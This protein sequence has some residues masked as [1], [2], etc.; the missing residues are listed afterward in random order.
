MR[1]LEF[2]T[3]KQNTRQSLQKKHEPCSFHLTNQVACKSLIGQSRGFWGSSRGYLRRQ[4]PQLKQTTA[5]RQ[6]LMNLESLEHSQTPLSKLSAFPGRPWRAMITPRPLTPKHQTSHRQDK[7]WSLGLSIMYQ[8][9]L[10]Y[11]L[12]Y[13]SFYVLEM[14]WNYKINQSINQY[15]TG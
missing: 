8:Y 2:S 9:C 3:R 4:N 14:L 6:W 12:H 1:L 5:S 7:P 11:I 15:L 13:V 10:F